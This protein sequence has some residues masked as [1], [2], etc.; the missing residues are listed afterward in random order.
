MNWKYWLVLRLRNAG[1]RLT[2]NLLN[3]NKSFYMHVVGLSVARYWHSYVTTEML[4]A[5]EIFRNLHKHEDFKKISLTGTGVLQLYS[6]KHIY[7]IPAGGLSKESLAKNYLNWCSLKQSESNNLVD[8]WLEEK[9]YTRFNFYKIEKLHLI[10][11]SEIAY[12]FVSKKL[13]GEL[14]DNE[15]ALIDFISINKKLIKLINVDLNGV[16]TD[17]QVKSRGYVGLLHGD[18]TSKNVLRNVNGDYVLID[19]DRVNFKGS[20]IIDDIH[21]WICELEIQLKKSW[22]YIFPEI[23]TGN[24]H[25]CIPSRLN[26]P[27][28]TKKLLM[29]YFFYRINEEIRD[30]IKVPLFYT[31][32]LKKCLLQIMPVINSGVK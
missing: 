27:N 8:Y 16:I 7:L 15:F 23:L 11:N 5:I 25:W 21:Y 9:T 29:V 13:I 4:T 12:N 1:A 18:L 14:N 22:L 30:D 17:L 19:L 10:E 31:K 2:R 20:Q 32:F 28:E 3:S 24:T 6:N 26:S